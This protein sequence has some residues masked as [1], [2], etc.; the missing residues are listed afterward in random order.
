MR[1]KVDYEMPVDAAE[2]W[3]NAALSTVVKLRRFVDQ[4]DGVEAGSAVAEMAD[5]V[6]GITTVC[7][8]ET[9]DVNEESRLCRSSPASEVLV[10]REDLQRAEKAVCQLHCSKRDWGLR[11]RWGQACL[12]VS[13]SVLRTAEQPAAGT[14]C[15]LAGVVALIHHYGVSSGLAEL[16]QVAQL[17]AGRHRGCSSESS[18]RFRERASSG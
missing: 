6:L 13:V 14:G 8:D 11:K 1:A 3:A 4:V 12:T 15:Q 7:G 5:V 9:R 16:R 2:D 17:L 10:L 18:V